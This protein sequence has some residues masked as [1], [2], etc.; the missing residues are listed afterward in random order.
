MD[1]HADLGSRSVWRAQDKNM[2]SSERET[3]AM[4]VLNK[5]RSVTHTPRAIEI[6]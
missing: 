6:P 4:V 3:V 5:A 2:F 1:A